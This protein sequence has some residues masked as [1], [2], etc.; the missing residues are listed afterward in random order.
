MNCRKLLHYELRKIEGFRKAQAEVN[1][2]IMQSAFK[3]V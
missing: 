2:P 3:M 1:E